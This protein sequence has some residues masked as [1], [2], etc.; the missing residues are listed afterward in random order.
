MGSTR[1]V[2]DTTPFA[3]ARESGSSIHPTLFG[4]SP[5]G[6]VEKCRK[7]VMPASAMPRIVEPIAL[8]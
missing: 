6:T 1:T 2:G 8:V 5:E 4:A 3:R 7:A